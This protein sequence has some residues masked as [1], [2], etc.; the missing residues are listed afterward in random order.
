MLQLDLELP[1]IPDQ[2]DQ[3]PRSM[4]RGVVF[5]SLVGLGWLAVWVAVHSLRTLFAGG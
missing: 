1:N 5:L 4:N 3:I 2:D